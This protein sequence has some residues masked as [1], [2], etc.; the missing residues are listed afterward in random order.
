[1]VMKERRIRDIM[2][3]LLFYSLAVGGWY[4][5]ANIV[6]WAWF[7]DNI[8]ILNIDIFNEKWLDVACLLFVFVF[9]IYYFIWKA[10]HHEN[11]KV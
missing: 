5:L 9:F 7:H 10:K 2:K 11:I 8:A 6:I 4:I 3:D 1:M